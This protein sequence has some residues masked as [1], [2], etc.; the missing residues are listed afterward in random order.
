MSNF[1]HPGYAGSIEFPVGPLAT[2]RESGI[3]SDRAAPGLYH[4]ILS[5]FPCANRLA[6]CTGP[7]CWSGAGSSPMN[8]QAH[9]K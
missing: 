8:E 2:P 4:F 5:A 3:S 6:W 7:L 1:R 9:S